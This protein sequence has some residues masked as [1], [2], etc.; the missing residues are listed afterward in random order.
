MAELHTF[1]VIEIFG[2]TIAGEGNIAGKLTSFVRLGYCDYRCVWCD[3]MHAVDPERVNDNAK[4]MNAVEIAD[5]LED[6]KA[7]WISLSGGNP[8]IHKH[9]GQLVDELKDRGW[10]IN[11]ETQGSIWQDWLQEC[12]TVTVSP[13]PPSSQMHTSLNMPTLHKMMLLDASI[14][15]IVV[16]D[17][18]DLHWAEELIS[19]FPEKDC[20]LSI[21]TRS[22][23]NAESLLTR[24][25]TISEKV[26]TSTNLAVSRATILPQ[27]H[28]LM[29]GHVQGV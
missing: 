27:L 26:L 2:P 3:S 20:Y 18:I 9:L 22:T 5:Q 13:K 19:R 7:P 10:L 8:A 29:W 16:F 11:V 12:D 17:D 1:P 15:K 25:R 4:W 14:L 21:G 6:R 28:V 24:Y 23:D